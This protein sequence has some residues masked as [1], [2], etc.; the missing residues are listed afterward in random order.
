MRRITAH[1]VVAV[2]VGGLLSPVATAVTAASASADTYGRVTTVVG[3]GAGLSGPATRAALRG[4]VHIDAAPDGSVLTTDRD[5]VL[6]VRPDTDTVA[7]APGTTVASSDGPIL[8]VAATGSSVVFATPS[9]VQRAASDGSTTRLL[10]RAG[11]RALDAGADG[12]VWV[13]T[14]YD[15][16]RILPSGAVLPV[17]TAANPFGDAIDLTVTPDGSRAYVLDNG[18]GRYGIYQVTPSG[19]GARVA[20][21]LLRD[22]GTVNE[23]PLA[24]ST[25]EVRTLS[26]DGT[27]IMMAQPRY[28]AVLRFTIG[29]TGR[30]RANRG[31]CG[32]GVVYR[33]T[34]LVVACHESDYV[35][36]DPSLRS[37]TVDG[38]DLGRIIGVD[39]AQRW[40][41]DGV[42][43]TDAYTDT[44]RGAA[45]LPDG[46]IVFTTEHGLVREI[47]TDGRLHTRA[48]LASLGGL[49][50]VAIGPDGTAYVVTGSGTIVKV[51][52]S[53]PPV[54]LTVDADATDVEVQA[55]GA[56]VVADA[57][58]HRLLR[59]PAG[60]SDATV[61]T[62]AV[63]T[64]ADIGLD[65]D[66]VLVADTGL[67]RVASDGTVTSVLTGGGPTTAA[68][69]DEG[70][71]TD[72]LI[73]DSQHR[74]QVLLPSG[75]FAPVR[76]QI[77]WWGAAQVQSVG[78]GDVLVS[79]STSVQL[80]TDA[81]LPT[82]APFS[83][84]AT[85]EPGRIDLAWDATGVTSVMVVAKHGTVPP[86]DRWDGVALGNVHSVTRMGAEPLQTDDPWSFAAFA[87]VQGSPDA[88]STPPTWSG[89]A[90]ATGNALED[91]VAPMP[92]VH[93]VATASSTSIYLSWGRP[94]DPDL[95]HVMVRMA[96]GTTPPATPDDGD[97]LASPAFSSVSVPQPVADQDYAVSIFDVDLHGNYSRWSTVA[98]LDLTPPAT[99]TDLQVAPGY[100]SAAVTFT[101]PSDPDFSR[102][103]Y[104]LV[105][106]TDV[107]AHQYASPA[108]GS[109]V[110]LPGL[111]MGTD[112]TLAVWSV[113][114]GSNVSEPVVTHFTTLLDT[115]PPGAVTDLS[116]TGGNYQ[117]TATW[118]LPAD[119][120]VARLTA[121]FTDNGTSAVSS[122]TLDKAA[123]QY[124]WP[125]LRGGR[126]YTVEVTATDTNGL[127]SP[128]STA[129]AV[130]NPDDNG[131]PPLIAPTTVTVSPLSDTSVTVSFPRPD[132]PDLASASA[133]IA[134]LGQDPRTYSGLRGLYIGATTVTGTVITP[135]PTTSYQLVLVLVDYNNNRTLSVGPNIQGAAGA[136]QLP[137]A[138]TAVTANATA[139]NTA[140]LSWA[141]GALDSL[142]VT[143]WT[144]TASSGSLTRSVTLTPSS[145]QAGF[146]DLD[147]RRDW[148]L[149][150]HG[151][152]A[153]GAGP[154]VSTGPVTVADATAPAPV[155]AATRTPAA[156]AEVLSWV[157]P[158]AF[159]FDHVVVTRV[160]A[161]AAETQVVYQGPGTSARAAGL[162]PG[163]AYGF[164]IR[165]YDHL[166]NVAPDPVTLT[167]IQSTLTLSG[168]ARLVYGG[169]ATLTGSLTWNGTQPGGRAVSI[170]S[171]PYG[172][173]V[174]TQ[175]AVAT[176]S[177]AGTFAAA[178]RPSVNTYYRAGYAGSDGM[179]GGYSAARLLP[180]APT[181]SILA[182][183]NSIRLGG[184]ITIA[185]TLA[186]RHPGGSILLQRW[187]GSAWGTVAVRTLSSASTASVTVRP[188]SRG[189]NTYRWVTPSDP[190]HA[191]GFG[192]PRAFRVY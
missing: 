113:D 179:G 164:Q 117:V 24:E 111:A 185:T 156:D 116:V 189:M 101:P 153:F 68:T 57:R 146:D 49:G 119:T 48:S 29:G 173:T 140:G 187:S 134:P 127:T 130:T 125:R 107:P 83:I 99:V 70:I 182:N 69:T 19:V 167:T 30:W 47:G 28:G 52:V 136:A 135:L 59:V 98:R 86:A 157:N 118:T 168:P 161:T 183:T 7:I 13:L 60:G 108:S 95:D 180:V 191:A 84:T 106:G 38:N 39:P 8:D 176:T 65:G 77:A 103:D 166:G 88:W 115:Q 25:S 149:T 76:A 18:Y 122:T 100:R 54:P 31:L 63:G 94:S 96:L 129:T 64:P 139:D 165:A 27:D 163:H 132:I 73:G 158:T 75:A 10:D 82:V 2:I 145:R 44:V 85:P 91:T 92:P 121:R 45:G 1:A 90:T 141:L 3:N 61:L 22:D 55:D 144:V 40:S 43:A 152:N 80:V 87:M 51:P 128:V 150:V 170:Q 41:P 181:M 33:G 104:A 131:A 66:T 62:D 110:N 26:T 102:I 6:R 155:T 78:N 148:T 133:G 42:Q 184:T 23:S 177:T 123:T 171:L 178:V 120:D 142:K 79:S 188:P 93:P 16:L 160:G 109:P 137:A 50:K 114:A 138:P 32:D 74:P 174:W 147:G 112:Y 58:A 21:N 12:V 20:G 11:V 162:L 126:S 97:L 124:T 192:A 14:Q 175:V 15:V 71:W 9:G 186:P 190:A 34:Q 35:H 159:D 172:S 37:V 46:R 72:P 5:R 89:P 105:R 53:G 81:G 151:N 17:T 143:S 169:S 36:P 67:R 56:V 154:L 4:D